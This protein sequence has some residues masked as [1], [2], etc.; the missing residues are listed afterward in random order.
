MARWCGVVGDKHSITMLT[1]FGGSGSEMPVL[2]HR[3]GLCDGVEHRINP[4]LQCA[5]YIPRD[6]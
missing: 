5:E 4:E 2:E 1:A 3:C 6:L